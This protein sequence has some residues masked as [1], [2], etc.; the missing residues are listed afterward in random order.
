MAVLSSPSRRKS[1][2]AG[3]QPL[4]LHRPRPGLGWV[5]L[6]LLALCGAQMLGVAHRVLHGPHGGAASV[7]TASLRSDAASHPIGHSALGQE[8]GSQGG[9]H[10]DEPG[11]FGHS[12][13]QS[14]QCRLFD[15][16]VHGD[17]LG[18]ASK[19]LSAARV[20]ALGAVL[21]VARL[22]GVEPCGYQAR[23]PPTLG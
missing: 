18:S 19:A 11:F 16:L 10:A 12:S 8:A 5:A 17:A 6:L 2:C 20:P 13:Q 22:R 14:D 21:P 15:Q 23:G 1:A 7:P 9:A 3:L 4:K